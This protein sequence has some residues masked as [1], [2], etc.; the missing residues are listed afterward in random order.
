MSLLYSITR[1]ASITQYL[2]LINILV[3]AIQVIY[4]T[5]NGNFDILNPL[6]GVYAALRNMPPRT[7]SE[8]EIA[9]CNLMPIE[10]L[11]ALKAPVALPNI[12]WQMGTSMFLHG[13]LLHLGIN[14]FVLWQFGQALE[15]VWDQTRKPG[16]FLKYYF[17]T[18]LGSAL[19]VVLLYIITGAETGLTLGA[20]GAVFGL[21]LAFGMLYPNQPIYLMMMIPVPAKYA[22]IVIGVLSVFFLFSGTLPGISHIGHLGGLIFGFILLRGQSLIKRL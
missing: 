18:G 11:L 20:S 4:Q 15:N 3:Y 17:I 19:C 22:V 7:L 14:M 2:V 12:L 13:G 5:T 21:L 1:F 10:C 6:S 9:Q 8:W 16:Y